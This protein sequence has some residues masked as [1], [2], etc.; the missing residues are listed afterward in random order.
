MAE[1][2]RAMPYSVLSGKPV[3]LREW[4]A[5]EHDKKLLLTPYGGPN[6][7]LTSFEKGTLAFL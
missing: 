7:A 6:F 2:D 3:S 4:A 1:A 5:E